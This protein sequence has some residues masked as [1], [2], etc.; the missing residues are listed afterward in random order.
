MSPA[1]PIRTLAAIIIALAAIDPEEAQQ[2]LFTT[3][4]PSES[5]I[6]SFGGVIGAGEFWLLTGNNG[7]IEE[8]AFLPSVT[9][10]FL[11]ADIALLYMRN[12]KRDF[13]IRCRTYAN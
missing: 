12:R 6:G 11:R 1:T 2:L 4:G 7:S 13:I 5:Y 3:F 8:A 10:P 9:A